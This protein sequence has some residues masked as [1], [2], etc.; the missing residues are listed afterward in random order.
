MDCNSWS[1]SDSLIL[2]LPYTKIPSIASNLEASR[3]ADHTVALLAQLDPAQTVL[4]VKLVERRE[5]IAS[6][7]WNTPCSH[8]RGE[9][10]R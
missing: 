4:Q 2:S 3:V 6:F 5:L 9:R 7:K 8:I 1:S 10:A